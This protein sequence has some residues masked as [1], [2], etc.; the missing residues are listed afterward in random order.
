MKVSLE[1]W[2]EAANKSR[3]KL[4][5]DLVILE[6]QLKTRQTWEGIVNDRLDRLENPPIP[7]IKGTKRGPKKVV[8]K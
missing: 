6:K 4:K 3:K 1:Q 7:A 2:V 5:A 8:K